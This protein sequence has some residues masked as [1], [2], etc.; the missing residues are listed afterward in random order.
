MAYQSSLGFLHPLPFPTNR[1]AGVREFVEPKIIPQILRA[2]CTLL[3]KKDK[4]API[5]LATSHAQLNILGH[6]GNRQRLLR[7]PL[8][9]EKVKGI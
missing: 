6:L 7:A 3:A 9:M 2:T 1:P 4:I 5:K 8:Y